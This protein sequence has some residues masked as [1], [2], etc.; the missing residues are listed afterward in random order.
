MDIVHFADIYI[1]MY[2]CTRSEKVED[3]FE[4]MSMRNESYK[5]FRSNI[6]NL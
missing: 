2:V 3:I 5:I 4:S 1:Y 6:V